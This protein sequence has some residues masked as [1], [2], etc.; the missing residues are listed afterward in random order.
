MKKLLIWFL[1]L[2]AGCSNERT[3][4]QIIY[5]E[6]GE[7]T[8]FTKMTSEYCLKKGDISNKHPDTWYLNICIAKGGSDG[9]YIYGRG[10]L[11]IEL[12]TL[13]YI[14]IIKFQEDDLLYKDDLI[15]ETIQKD[16][17]QLM[18]KEKRNEEINNI[19]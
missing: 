4:Y 5:K 10:Y 7:K 8:Y 19:N 13:D 18:E 2:I 11:V 1:L 17:H 3:L 12:H 15:T 9:R 16:I 6:K 14:K